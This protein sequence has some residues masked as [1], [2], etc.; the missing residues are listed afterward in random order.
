MKTNTTNA[1][2]ATP[3]TAEPDRSALQ[4]VVNRRLALRLGLS[5]PVA[6]VVAQLAGLGPKEARQ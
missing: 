6:A 2:I 4:A 1:V 3:P 5:L